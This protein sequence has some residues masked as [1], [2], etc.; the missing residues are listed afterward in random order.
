MEKYIWFYVVGMLIM[1]FLNAIQL[2]KLS[3]R[4]FMNWMQI[5]IYAGSIVWYVFCLVGILPFNWFFLG[6]SLAY[7]LAFTLEIWQCASNKD[8]E[9]IDTLLVVVAFIPVLLAQCILANVLP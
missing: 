9:F 8:R 1:I 3:G 2:K 7:I 6:T 4:G 5:M